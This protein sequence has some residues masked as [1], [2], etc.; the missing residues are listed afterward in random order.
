MYVVL[1]K[2]KMAYF[3]GVSLFDALQ[4]SNDYA[5]CSVVQESLSVF[6]SELNMI[7]ALGDIVIPI[8]DV[9]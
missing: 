2:T 8:P 7:V 3:N 1:V 6:D 9:F 4:C 5:F